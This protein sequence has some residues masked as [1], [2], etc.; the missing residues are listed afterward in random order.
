M[1]RKLPLN[2]LFFRIAISLWLNLLVSLRVG[3]RLTQRITDISPLKR[4][5]LQPDPARTQA[6]LRI[7][8][9]TDLHVNLLPYDYFADRPAPAF[10][11]AQTA[12]M[13]RFLRGEVPNSLLF[14]N[15]DFLQGNPLSDWIARDSGFERGQLHPMI[16]A[17]N[18]LDYDAGTLGNH[19]FD[20][21]LDFLTDALA[22]AIFPVVSANTLITGAGNAGPDQPLVSPYIILN[23]QIIASDGRSYLVKIGVIGFAPPQLVGWNRIILAGRVATRDILEAA[24]FYV[25]QMRAAGAQLIVALCHS[26]ITDEAPADRMENAS[27]P[28]AAVPGIDVILAG[29]T[30]LQ[31]PGPGLPRTAA[32]DPELGSL[33]GKPAV[34]AGYNG[35][36]VGVIDVLLDLQPQGWVISAH[37]VWLEPVAVRDDTDAIR[38]RVS[39][40]AQVVAAAQQGHDT[41]L[42][43]IRKPVGNTTVPI[44][45]YF[46][47]VAPDRSLQIVAEAQ[48]AHAAQILRGTLWADLPLLSAVAPAKVGGRGGETHFIDIPA[49]RLAL[50]HAADLSVFPNSFCIVE[51]NGAGLVDWLEHSA[52]IFQT[53]RTGVTDQPL[54]DPDF[55][56]YHFDVVDGVT[57]E[58]DPSQPSRTDMWGQLINPQ[59]RR[60]RNLRWNGQAI[61]PD[62]RLAVA[63][64]S[65]RV[66]GGGGFGVVRHARLIHHSAE[67]SRDVVIRFLRATG[68]LDPGPREIWRFA[69]LPGTAAWF[70][71]GPGAVAHLADVAG[72]GISDAGPGAGRFHRFLLDF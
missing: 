5:S 35:S 42:D 52:G 12:S 8:E 47:L 7:L 45:S 43:L 63:T 67:S 62:Q 53:I 49:G 69:A 41:I 3:D 13:V 48:R 65:Y 22:T 64:N 37:Q 16:A 51:I 68:P 27:V 31:F 72:R 17:M 50:R 18:T 28:L 34:M 32:I 19:E 60:I 44:H 15:G 40:D 14:D 66:G 55:P 58:I 36:H 21:G 59:A 56:S 20:Y 23:R 1:M 10:G 46:A 26:G 9:T 70:D 57:Y 2:S 71:S 33:H 61:A 29:H 25:P 4:R 6:V 39:N 38:S 11:L 24:E 30:H 54:I